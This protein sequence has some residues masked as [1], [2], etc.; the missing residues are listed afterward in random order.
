MLEQILQ[1]PNKNIE[2]KLPSFYNLLKNGGFIIPSHINELDIIRKLN[3]ESSEKP[4]LSLIILP[5]L[6]CNFRCWYCYESHQSSKMSMHTIH[7]IQSFIKNEV[8]E[9]NIK[10]IDVAWF[11]GEPF[12][13]YKD[14]M[15]PILKFIK[16]FCTENNITYVSSATTNGFLITKEI[17]NS[18]KDFNFYD[19]QITLDGERDYHNKVRHSKITSSFDTILQNVGYICSSLPNA[20]ILLRINYDKYN[21]K[22]Q[23]ILK[24]I[25]ELIPESA[26]KQISFLLRKI[27]QVETF[28][29]EISLKDSF[30]REV[31]KYGF[32]YSFNKDWISD[33]IPC[34]AVRKH[35][36]MIT[37]EGL[38]GKCT[39]K[40]NFQESAIGKLID[41]GTI[42]WNKEGINDIYSQTLFE[43]ND[44]LSCKLLPLC[45]GECPKI[46]DNKGNLPQ[47]I[48]CRKRRSD[49]EIM[50][51]IR[52]YC[53]YYSK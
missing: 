9:K 34:Y 15:L 33:F 21:L 31:Y 26:K 44:C 23:N 4:I 29:E 13:Y 12:L 52:N 51:L 18:L 3:K 16:D 32:T 48:K 50:H 27:W 14:V 24:Q 1:F 39:A 28:E 20:N 5:T 40:D 19:F 53:H 35:T 11:G 30:I 6:N 37:H 7:A 42:S 2:Q 8:K 36:L 45:M 38:I 22:S 49:E 46:I 43:N 25:D 41:N 17:V 10:L 47:Y